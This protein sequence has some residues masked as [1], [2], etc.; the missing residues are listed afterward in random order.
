MTTIK[1][2]REKIKY[3]IENWPFSA[4][5]VAFLRKKIRRAPHGEIFVFHTKYI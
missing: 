3:E 2:E 5:A 4:A 1:Y